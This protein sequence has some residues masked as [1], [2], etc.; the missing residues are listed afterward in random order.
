MGAARAG[1]GAWA[2][3]TNA[4]SLEPWTDRQGRSPP[5]GQSGEDVY[6]QGAR[7]PLH[8]E[9]GLGRHRA[10]D[11]LG[12]EGLFEGAGGVQHLVVVGAVGAGGGHQDLCAT[13]VLWGAAVR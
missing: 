6:S 12:V 9:L 5:K 3:A 7:I 11:V 8:S 1:V 13:G 2:Q 10:E 4:Q